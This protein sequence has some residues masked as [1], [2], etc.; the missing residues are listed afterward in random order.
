MISSPTSLVIWRTENIFQITFWWVKSWTWASSVHLKPGRPTVSWAA[1]KERW[2]AGRGTWFTLPL[3]G[4]ICSAVGRS[5]PSSTRRMQSCWSR[6]RGGQQRWL[7]DWSMYE[8]RLRELS[9]FSLEKA[10]ERLCC[11]FPV[12]E[13]NLWAGGGPIWSN[14]D[15]T[16]QNGIKVKKRKFRR[17]SLLRGWW[18]M[19]MGC[20]GTLQMPHPQRMAR[21]D[22]ALG[23]LIWWV[24]T[25]SIA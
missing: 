11:S 12:L 23:S 24:S 1:S 5:R 6:Y 10:L 20:P 8:E 9:L 18:G 25:L 21:L 17:N 7:E 14:R 4:P 2:P 22:W 19:G 13:R 3:W 15:R 16:R